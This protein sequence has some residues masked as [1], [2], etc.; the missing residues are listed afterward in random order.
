MGVR[1]VPGR[2]PNVSGTSFVSSW[3][4]RKCATLLE[5]I[6][7]TVTDGEQ[8]VFNNICICLTCQN[9]LQLQ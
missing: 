1:G 8:K 2:Q 7:S 4:N 9:R 5:Q 3:D 6:M